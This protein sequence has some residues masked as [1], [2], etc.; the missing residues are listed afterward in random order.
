MRRFGRALRRRCARC[1]GR[2]CNTLRSRSCAG[3][4]LAAAGRA[5]AHKR[6][7][8]SR[9]GGGDC[10]DQR[11]ELGLAFGVRHGDQRIEHGRL[12][13]AIILVDHEHGIAGP[14]RRAAIV[15]YA[16]RRPAISGHMI[17]A[18]C[19]A[20]GGRDEPAV[21]GA[22]GRGDRD[23]GPADGHGRSLV[24]D[25]GDASRH[26]WPVSRRPRPSRQSAAGR[27]RIGLCQAG[28]ERRVVEFGQIIAHRVGLHGGSQGSR[29]AARRKW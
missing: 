15:L 21:G 1:R 25:F 18:G 11:L 28:K 7:H 3:Y 29:S 12:G 23:C 17:T 6:P 16:S 4:R 9:Y 22:I 26:A 10:R 20:R 2:P 27:W 8:R 19:F 13:P 14:A 5:R 24:G